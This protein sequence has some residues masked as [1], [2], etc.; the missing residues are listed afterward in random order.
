[1]QCSIS[2]RALFGWDGQKARYKAE[3]VRWFELWTEIEDENRPLDQFLSIP[4]YSPR[5]RYGAQEYDAIGLNDVLEELRTPNINWCDDPAVWLADHDS[6]NPRAY[7]GVM[8]AR[9]FNEALQMKVRHSLV[10]R[11]VA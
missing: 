7:N 9:K 3:N 5:S 6:L 8:S 4:E 11:R 1:M 2:S 10:L